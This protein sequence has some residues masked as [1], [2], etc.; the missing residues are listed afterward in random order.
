MSAINNDN[1]T[2]GNSQYCQFQVTLLTQTVGIVAQKNL[3]KNEIIEIKIFTTKKL[4]TIANEWR[5]RK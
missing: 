1:K 2:N 4:I 5:W 3:K